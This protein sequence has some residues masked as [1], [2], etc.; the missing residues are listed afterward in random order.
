MYLLQRPFYDLSRKRTVK[1]QHRNRNSNRKAKGD[2]MAGIAVF[3]PNVSL[4]EAAKK[5]DLKQYSIASLECIS[6]EEIIEKA[7]KAEEEGADIIVVRG[8]QAMLVK[9]AVHIP[10]VEIIMTG[11]ELGLLASRAKELAK[12][13]Q[14][15]IALIGWSTMFGDT[16]YFS[17]LYGIDW[18]FYALEKAESAEDAVRLAVQEGA[19]VI[20]GGKTVMR[21]AE[22]QG[23]PAIFLESRG[24]SL[25][26]ALNQAEL[27]LHSMREERKHNAQF[28]AFMNNSFSGMAKIGTD[29]RIEEVNQVFATLVQKD[30]GAC[31][32]KYLIDIVKDLEMDAVMDVLSGKRENYSTM[33]LMHEASTVVSLNPI[34]IGGNIE[35]AIFLGT[36]IK[37][38]EKLEQDE[39]Q[40]KYLKGYV[41]R[42]QFDDLKKNFKSEKK[43][44]ED[45]K[46]FA[47]SSS[48]MLLAGENG[49]EI[50]LVAQCI[51]N[52]S[53]RRENPYVSVSMNGL[54]NEEQMEL[55][56]GYYDRTR[57]ERRS[58]V[59]LDA[60]RGT[61]VIHSVDKM[62]LQVQ[63]RL[64]QTLLN[65]SLVEAEAK[66]IQ[67]LNVRIIATS[68]KDLYQLM[69]DGK[70]R[71]DI[72]YMLATMRLYIPPLRERREALNSLIDEYLSQYFEQYT[73]YYVL[74]D[75]AKNVMLS[76][77]W[78]GNLTQLSS[79]CER[80]VLTAGKRTIRGPLVESLLEELYPEGRK[81]MSP[82]DKMQRNEVVD[83]K[84]NSELYQLET[85]MRKYKGN[86]ARIAEAMG[87]ST[88]TLWRRMKKY[89]L[90]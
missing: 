59:L 37:R 10:V 9:P 23:M 63:Y 69:K 41:A 83:G 31:I 13:E 53:T 60:N 21:E 45:G 4:W 66:K 62:G 49:T 65:R 27:M 33:L 14:P 44:I 30:E 43:V 64:T 50:E 7:K 86:R 19:E 28:M 18:R 84:D 67:P 89:G 51:H 6:T 35:G 38:S 57:R 76:Y 56:F 5:M 46:L 24:E 81:V 68:S 42:T 26:I 34:N 80:L 58:G 79:F 12:S 88:T 61:I 2:K 78:N 47:L 22:K 87:I 48:P 72:Y 70:M 75:E 85:M 16:T 36:R 3:V 17:E 71:K 39:I 55:L 82:D 11:Q 74:T 25:Q 15:V 52:Y 54:N 8:K 1:E 40:R 90:S 20:I 29:G 73:Q 32:G 77:P